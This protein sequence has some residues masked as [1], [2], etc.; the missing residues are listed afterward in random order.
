MKNLSQAV[1]DALSTN[2]TYC[3]IIKMELSDAT[4]YLTEAGHDIEYDGN[5]YV[6]SG[7]VVGIGSIKQQK[8][9]KV[10][11]VDLEFSAVDQSIVALFEN[12]N[13]QN[14]RVVISTLILDDDTHQSIGVSNSI[15]HVIN[16]YTIDDDET[17]AII[18]VNVSNF[19]AEFDCVRSITTT[20]GNFAR[21]YPSTTSFINSKDVGNDL[22]WGGE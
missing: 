10:A 6:S 22:K 17:K 5:T 3:R 13:Q 9:L 15:N 8:E 18:S 1:I 7:L 21:F 12:T 20:Q 2:Y 14:R 11:S 16:S 4:I 19:L